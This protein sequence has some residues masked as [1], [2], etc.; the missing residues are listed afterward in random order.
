VSLEEERE[1]LERYKDQLAKE[2]EGVKRRIDEL[3]QCTG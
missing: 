1:Q 2:M 3:S